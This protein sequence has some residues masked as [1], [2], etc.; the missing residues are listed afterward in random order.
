MQ[1]ADASTV[2]GDFGGKT[3]DY[4]GVIST[5]FKRGGKFLARTDGP[6]GK[7]HEYEIAYT[8]GVHP[9]QQY[10]IAFPGGRYQALNVCWDSRPARD[11]G[12]SAKA[13]SSWW[14]VT[15]WSRN[16]TTLAMINALV[17]GGRELSMGPMHSPGNCW[18]V[19][20]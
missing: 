13:R 11:G 12:H 4:H 2:L 1:P 16:T 18:L 17:T 6:D 20:T 19:A 3:F 15:D 14:P 7:L 5:F 8:F 10:L 9:L